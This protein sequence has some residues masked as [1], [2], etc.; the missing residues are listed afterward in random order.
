MPAM[1]IMKTKKKLSTTTPKVRTHDGAAFRK[2][3][4]VELQKEG[5]IKGFVDTDWESFTSWHKILSKFNKPQGLWEDFEHDHLVGS[6]SCCGVE[7]LYDVRDK[8]KDYALFLKVLAGSFYA[9]AK[10]SYTSKK[11][12]G[13]GIVFYWDNE[14]SGAQVFECLEKLGWNKVF[15]G[16]NPVHDHDIIGYNA[17]YGD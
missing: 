1:N 11:Y 9:C 5:L 10:S 16:N 4:L 3:L 2:R 8:A 6:N 7:E 13:P 17:Y 12:K 14:K 15:Q